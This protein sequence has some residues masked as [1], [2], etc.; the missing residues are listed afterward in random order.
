MLCNKHPAAAALMGLV[1]GAS[2]GPACA[3]TTPSL[4]GAISAD[5]GA[6]ASRPQVTP[7][8][9]PP[10]SVTHTPAAKLAA[11]PVRSHVATARA[12]AGSAV[13]TGPVTGREA[14]AQPQPPMQSQTQSQAQSQPQPQSPPQATPEAATSHLTLGDVDNLARNK[15]A[16]T[17]RGGDAP[18]ASAAVATTKTAPADTSSRANAPSATVYAPRAHVEPVVFTG[19]YSDGL[20]Q[21]V[22][23]LYNGSVYPALIGEKLLNGWI[24]RRVDGQMVTVSEGR[25]TR[26]VAMSGDAP[27][28]AVMAQPSPYGGAP[29]ML[30]DL[31]QPLPRAI[32]APIMQ[33]GR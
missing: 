18:A 4:A 19:A 3:A 1:L 11:V 27:T 33:T 21:H 30:G 20:G 13:S 15:L 8:A 17:L 16:S 29:Q 14:Q 12:T 25:A 31:S 26:H 5:T 22:L 2:L 24:A 6:S 10:A 23:Y 9:T 28:T 32:G 7:P